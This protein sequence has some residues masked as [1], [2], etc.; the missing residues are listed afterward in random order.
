MRCTTKA[1]LS[2]GV[3]VVASVAV[4]QSAND[5]SSKIDL[6]FADWHSAAPRLIRGSLEER[7]IL[8][9]GDGVNPTQKGEVLR[10]LNSYEYAT[11]AAKSF[12]ANNP[13]RWATGEST[14]LRRVRA[15]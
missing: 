4:A 13:A 1:L 3:L 5:G 8:T 7:P 12:D 11:L 10:F 6:Y 14:S 2:A 9:H 15:R